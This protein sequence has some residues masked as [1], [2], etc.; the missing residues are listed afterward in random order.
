MKFS[1]SAIWDDA[2]AMLKAHSGIVAAI[3]GTFIFLPTLLFAYFNPRPVVPADDISAAFEA[4]STYMQDN[5]IELMIVGM[6][7]SMALIAILILIIGRSGL[8]VGQALGRAFMLLLVFYIAYFIAC[9]AIGLGLVA[10]IIPGLYLY[11]RLAAFLIPITAAEE[12]RNPIEMLKRSWEL[13]K[14]KGWAILGMILL[15]ALAGTLLTGVINM[16]VRLVLLLTLGK[17]VGEFGALVVS[18][19]LSAAL[20]VV[21][22]LICAA[23]YRNRM[24]ALPSAAGGSVPADQR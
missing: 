24:A 18:S 3:A 11:A 1:Y 16:V 23:M 13:S 7:S 21:I 17:D 22:A 15:V 8:T 10:L 20:A 12:P 14:G 5:A 19:A 4:F 6:L 9:V 2:M